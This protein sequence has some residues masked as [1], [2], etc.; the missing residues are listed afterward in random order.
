MATLAGDA[1]RHL[2]PLPDDVVYPLDADV[3]VLFSA[4]PE[5]AD[6]PVGVS[7]AGAGDPGGRPSGGARGSWRSR[8][9]RIRSAARTAPGSVPGAGRICNAGPCGCTARL[10]T[11]ASMAVPKRKLSKSRKRLRR[12][13]HKAAG[14]PTQACPR[15]GSP[16]AA[17]PGV[18]DLRLL[19]RQEDGRGRGR[20]SVIRV[21]LDAMGGDHA[22]Q[23][24]VEG[25]F[26]RLAELPPATSS[27]Q[28][29]GRADAIEAELARHPGADRAPA[30]DAR[31]ARRHRHGRE[32]A[33]RRPQEAELEPRRRPRPAEGR[34]L[35]RVRLG[36][37][38]RRRRWRLAPAARAARG[39][40]A[41]H[42]RHLVPDRRRSRCWC[43]MPAPTST[44]PPASWSASPGWAPST[45]RT[46]WGEPSPM[47]GLLN[48][49]EED[50]KGNA[51]AKE[52]HQLLKQAPRPQLR[53]QHRGPRH[54][55]RA[56]R[57]TGM[58]DVV[59]C[60]G[61][62]GNIVLKF[63][64]SVAR[65]IVRL[66]KR[67]APPR[68]WSSPTMQRGLPHPRLLR[69]RRRAA[70][71]R[72]GRL[73]HLPRR[74]RRPT[75]SRTPSGWR[76]RPWPRRPQ[77]AHRRRVRPA[78]CGARS[79]MQRPDRRRSP[80]LGVCRAGAGRDQRRLRGPR[81]RPPTSGSSSAPASASGA[82]AGADET[83][84]THGPEAQ[85]S[86]ALGRAGIS[87]ADL[88]AIVVATATPD[89]LLPSTACDL[90]A[91]LGAERAAAFDIVRRL[92]RVRLR[93][94]RGRRP[95]R[96]RAGARTCWWSAARSSP[97]SPTSRTAPPRSSSATAPAP[98]SSRRAPRD[99]RGILSTFIKS[100]GALAELLYIPAA[101]TVDPISEK[102]VRERSPLHEDGRAR[103]V[104]ARGADHG[105][106]L[107]RGAPPRRDHGRRRSTCWCRTRPTSGS[108]R[109]PPSTPGIPL[110]KVM[111]N[112]DRYGNTSAASIPLALARPRQTGRLKPGMLVLLVAFGAGF[113]WGSAV[114]PVVTRADVPRAG[115]AEGRHGEGPRRALPGGARDLRA[116]ST[117]ALG[118]PLS[119]LMWEG[120][121]EELTLTHNAQP[122]ILA[123][124]AA[125]WA[126]V[127]RALG[128]RSAAAA[129]HSLGEYSAYVAAGA[130]TPT[131][132]A[133][134]GAPAGRAD[135]RGGH[136]PARRDG[137]GAR[138][139][140]PT[141][142]EA[143]C[144]RGVRPPAEVAV[145]ANLNAPG[146]DRDLRR[147]RRGGA[148]RRGAARPRGA[149]RV[150]AAQG[151]RRVPLAADGAGGGRASTRRSPAAT[152]ARPGR[153]R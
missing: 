102:V 74:P 49:G 52:A 122:A 87:A 63:Y 137:R 72:E 46:S 95:D 65:L 132:A 54:R 118:V 51:V 111:V 27:I 89:R 150:I 141:E 126:V 83:V 112:V 42:G 134:A 69:V 133:A 61:F 19:P 127:G 14:M 82:C 110:D 38:H 9:R 68:S 152:F 128:R 57:S 23:A 56:P 8:C 117:T 129:G 107:R 1:A 146:P 151:E 138:P 144:A 131:E 121:E 16:Q 70:A 85:P 18:P 101:A 48:V 20:L 71:R 45:C 143:A 142:V 115:G 90:Q 124:S 136:P 4:D 2:P 79:V 37:Q 21:A 67:E 53:R 114:D 50:E 105:R 39:R 29:V 26:R 55:R 12:G 113:T 147:S 47:V 81:S 92:L 44:A 24:E 13:H 80:G 15:C 5:A 17:A 66:V 6:D 145:A 149:K 109:P 125:V 25:A 33:R 116:R 36:R 99:G 140:P 7:A 76:S 108:S 94:H 106:G 10:L 78:R 119:R 64:E 75:P 103:G 93:P 153:S 34:G 91:L 97:P 59:V 22:P 148:G 88:D 28:L 84:A 73:H 77:P 58:L 62:V 86:M 60:D 135:V 100:D 120:P 123:H 98:R 96:Q 104:Q 40:G 35:R 41:R 130:L 3:E 43:S 31:G 11:E 32:A 30:R 139:R